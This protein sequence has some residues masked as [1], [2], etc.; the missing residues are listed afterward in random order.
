MLCSWVVTAVV[1]SIFNISVFRAPL[2]ILNSSSVMQSHELGFE[3]LSDFT[4]LKL[5]VKSH[6]SAYN[7]SFKES[8]NNKIMNALHKS[9]HNTLLCSFNIISSL[10]LRKAN[11]IQVKH[12]LQFTS[13]KAG[14]RV[15]GAPP[16]YM[17]EKFIY[18]YNI[19]TKFTQ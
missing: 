4:L 18:M 15:S 10:L 11:Q 7:E 3:Q 17:T 8:Q 5:T 12:S 9:V 16:I 19:A 14:K 6:I 1:L 13:G 2:V